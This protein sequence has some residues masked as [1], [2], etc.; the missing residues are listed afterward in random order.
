M[1][2]VLKNTGWNVIGD[3]VL[4]QVQNGLNQPR[5][6]K[7]Y[8]GGIKQSRYK[9][10]YQGTLSRSLG[11]EV[12]ERNTDDIFLAL[13][14]PGEG[15]EAIKGKIFLETGRLPGVGVSIDVLRPW[16]ETK[17]PGF[18]ALDESSKKW[19]LIKISSNIK[20]KGLGIFPVIDEQF[21]QRLGQEYETW[22]NQL[23]DAQVEQLP[24]LDRVFELFNN[25]RFFDD[26]T[27]DIFR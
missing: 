5:Q 25:I 13:T 15:T 21:T 27:I 12:I 8:F 20:N 9:L 1:A 14:Y 11:M 22:F 6:R 26:T 3:W 18:N 2:K 19:T 24:G 17:L 23:T 4:E 10:N 7:D 16:A